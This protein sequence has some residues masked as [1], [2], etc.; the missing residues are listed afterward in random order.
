LS[1]LFLLTVSIKQYV[2]VACNSAHAFAWDM[3][4]AEN[5]TDTLSWNVS[6]Y[7]SSDAA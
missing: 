5:G 2:L 3:L 6:Y 4:F 7:I 1:Q